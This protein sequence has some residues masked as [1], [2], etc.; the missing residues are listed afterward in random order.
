MSSRAFSVRFRGL[1]AFQHFAFNIIRRTLE[2]AVGIF[3]IDCRMMFLG[4]FTT[5][6]D[7]QH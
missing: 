3:F 4:I 6:D 7:K 2:S 5:F 1:I